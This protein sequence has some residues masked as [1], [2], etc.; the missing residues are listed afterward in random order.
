MADSSPAFKESITL[1]A[2]AVQLAECGK[3]QD[4][5][6]CMNRGVDAAPERPAAYND[7]AQLLRLML[8]DEGKREQ[9]S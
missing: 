5:L 7:R 1:C 4:A 9:C 8:R 2:R 3:L 6:V